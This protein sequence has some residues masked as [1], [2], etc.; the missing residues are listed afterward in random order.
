[1]DFKINFENTKLFKLKNVDLI[2]ML[3]LDAV[4]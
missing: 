4:L 1:M 2:Q 3:V